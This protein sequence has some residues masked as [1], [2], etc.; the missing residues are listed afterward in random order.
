MSFFEYSFGWSVDYVIIIGYDWF[1]SVNCL[2]GCL[3]KIVVVL[4]FIVCC[5]WCVVDVV[6]N[7]V[8]NCIYWIFYFG[9]GC[10]DWNG[11]VIVVFVVFVWVEVVVVSFGGRK[12]V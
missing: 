10:V 6:R 5:G 4:K 11:V 7:K 2:G 1:E 9:G 3:I 12:I 8:F